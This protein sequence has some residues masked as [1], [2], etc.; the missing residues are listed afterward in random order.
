MKLKEGCDRTG[1]TKRTVRFYE[2]KELLVP[3]KTY[4]NGREY[5]EYSEE[6]VARLSE[7]K[8]SPLTICW[9]EVRVSETFPMPKVLPPTTC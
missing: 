4:K 6:D 8:T 2:E 5:R 9:P 1:L 3:Q 7:Y